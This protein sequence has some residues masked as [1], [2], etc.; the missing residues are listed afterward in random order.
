MEIMC[1][2]LDE[3]VVYEQSSQHNIYSKTERSDFKWRCNA[4]KNTLH[5]F[6]ESGIV[7]VNIRVFSCIFIERCFHA[8]F[9]C[10]VLVWHMGNGTG[11]KKIC[12]ILVVETK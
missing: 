8:E 5:N 10:F 6:I 11:G 3:C 1:E 4:N 7:H 2:Y 9:V 12:V